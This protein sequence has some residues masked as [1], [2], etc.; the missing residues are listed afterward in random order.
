[1]YFN[2]HTH[3]NS[4]E[5][6][7]DRHLY[8]QHCLQRGIEKLCVVGY[9]V[10][11][12]RLAVAIAHEY[13]QVYA[14]VGI[15]PNDC[16]NTTEEDMKI[17]DKLANDDKVIG[18]GETG[19]DYYYD[20]PKD[21]QKE[22]F[23]GHIE[24]VKRCHKPIIIHCRDA[25]EETYSILEKA[26]IEGIMHCY[27]GSDQMALRF[28]KIGFYISLAGPVTFKNA[29]MPKR[30]AELVP[31][32]KLLIETDDPYLTPVPFRG[33]HNEPAYCIYIAKEIA[34]LK[35]MDEEEIALQTYKNA[36]KIFQLKG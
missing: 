29:K 34:R 15:S 31:L 20:V 30:T 24:I 6:Y 35:N 23:L 17:I 22:V 14:A 4:P 1:M 9:D 26:H 12:S 33:K 2:T 25:Y 36:C 7:P 18:I 27:S 16:E 13:P 3:L 28:T 32:D 5:Q 8:I 11:S 21:K 19:L 10:E